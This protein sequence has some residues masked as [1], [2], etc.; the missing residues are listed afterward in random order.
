MCWGCFQRYTLVPVVND[1]VLAMYDE[2]S[3]PELNLDDSALLHIPVADMNCDDQLFDLADDF[4]I[5]MYR[6]ASPRERQ[7]FDRLAVLTPQER[8]TAVA[9][10]WG[11]IS[12]DGVVRPDCLEAE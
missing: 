12:R 3:V 11:Y 2:L 9:M 6:E 10:E 7:A 8:A 1:R 4:I 5:A